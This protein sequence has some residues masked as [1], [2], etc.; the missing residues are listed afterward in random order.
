[1]VSLLAST[2]EKISNLLKERALNASQALC[3]RDFLD[4]KGSS[5]LAPNGII[6]PLGVSVYEGVL[7]GIG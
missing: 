7:G 2:R 3:A 4:I 6:D 5:M 1:M